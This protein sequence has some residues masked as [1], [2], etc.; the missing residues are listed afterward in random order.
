MKEH[1]LEA[2]SILVEKSGRTLLSDIYLQ[3]RTGEV[4]GLLGRNGTGKSTLLKV[5]FGTQSTPDRNIR[6]DG[7]TIPPAAL[8]GK[9]IAY[10]PQHSFLPSSLSIRRII[11]LYIP[12]PAAAKQVAQDERIKPHL[13]KNATSLS[14][15]ELRYLEILLLLH[16]PA[17][18]VLLDE[19]FSGIEPIYQ[20]RVIDLIAQHREKKGFIITDQ[21]YRGVVDLS[22][23]LVL[24][25][26][27]RAV[28]LKQKDELET[29][30][31]LPKGSLKT[32]EA[33]DVNFDIDKQTL[34]D[35]DLFDKGRRGPVFDLFNK[36]R[37]T[38]GADA[39]ERLLKTPSTNR[40][41]LESRRDTIRF[42]ADNGI[43]LRIDRQ[44][45]AGIEHYLASGI[46]LFP[47]T[48]V[49]A[50]VYTIRNEIKASAHYYTV[51][52]GVR[53]T[54]SLLRYLLRQGIEWTECGAPDALAERVG[55]MLNELTDPRLKALLLGPERPLTTR[56]LARCDQFL[57]GAG[58]NAL[59]RMLN[60]LHE[61][62]AYAA[63][64]QTA[65]HHEFCFPHYRDGN[66]PAIMAQC[67]F[68]PLLASPVNNDFQMGA[69]ANCCFISGANMAGKS[70]FLRS[71]GLAVYLSHVGFPVP[72]RQYET[73]I[74][75]GLTTTV[76]LSDDISQGQ[77]HFYT[78]VRRIREVLMAI[79]Q[80]KK[81]VVIFDELFRGTNLKDAS[82]AS[83]QV[84]DGLAGIKGSLFLIS[85][86]IV[87]IAAGLQR[88]PNIF[89]ACF[90]ST[91]EGGIP[92][93]SYKLRSGISNE[94]MG[95]TILRNEGILEMLAEMKR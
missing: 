66:E 1:L 25:E 6:I 93:Y 60:I 17:P 62:E 41:L 68:H 92:W 32:T 78:E 82:D 57:R 14:G 85:T 70:T 16:L 3:C 52:N 43:D 29:R 50:A 34:R 27:G 73:T 75:N 9:W 90:E 21:V 12:D 30:G 49:D 28:G 55:E 19:P 24:L 18:F 23:R 67:L 8:R 71:T 20:Q 91:M 15:G 53:K 11:Q 58:I 35:L 13:R 7:Q 33:A 87:E 51:T 40:Q 38:G 10:L 83:L 36:T 56:D 2:D 65:Q 94:R 89:F 74:F 77:S 22:D 39:L 79:R 72:A 5:L 47:A 4:V 86:H 59:R 80:K 54:V 48:F 31:Y 69:A 76:N 44:Q 95:M 64:A 81:M 26:N 45:L 84:I 61:W 37:T 46:N 42:F 88:N 63:V